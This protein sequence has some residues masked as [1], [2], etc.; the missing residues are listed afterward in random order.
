MELS[1]TLLL[2]LLLISRTASA[3]GQLL[4][5]SLPHPVLGESPPSSKVSITEE[6][7]TLER[8][9][10]RG[11]FTLH[12]VGGGSHSFSYA[13][14]GFLAS[15]TLLFTNK[16]VVRDLLGEDPN[17]A[18]L[19]VIRSRIPTLTMRNPLTQEEIHPT[20]LEHCLKEIDVCVLRLDPIPLTDETGNPLF[21]PLFLRRNLTGLN[22]K[23]WLGLVGNSN[24]KGLQ[25][26]SA[27]CVGKVGNYSILHCIPT[28]PL[29]SGGNSG[30]PVFDHEGQ[31]VAMDGYSLALDSQ[32]E[33]R[34]DTTGLAITTEAILE[35][36]QIEAPE[37]GSELL[38]Q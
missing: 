17:K 4:A 19:T 28:S 2:I 37:L 1:R 21:K 30:S 11:T 15:E 35:L 16:H 26:S 9:I 34:K 24:A 33:L 36:L 32:C 7:R 25:A 5:P 8:R 29:S 6:Q 20:K 13:A 14:T 23:N 18:S 22:E 31:V 3:Q 12:Y 38:R 10:A 27:H